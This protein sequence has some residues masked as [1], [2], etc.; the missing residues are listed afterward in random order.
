M[1]TPA[2]FISYRRNDCAGYA[3]RLEDALE[4]IYGKGSVFRDVHDIAAGDDFKAVIETYLQGVR[5]SLVLIG[6]QWFGTRPDGSRR[7]DEPN[8]F[9][10]LEVLTAVTRTAKVVPILL[11]GATMPQREHL[12]EALRALADKQALTLEE[13]SWDS[14]LQRL[15]SSLDIRTARQRRMAPMAVGILLLLAAGGVAYF[16]AQHRAPAAAVAVT[17]DPTEKTRAALPGSWQTTVKYYW[18]DSYN[19]QFVFKR[20]AGEL[21]G[22]ASY[23]AYPR[24]IEQ[25]AINDNTV[26]FLTHTYQSMNEQQRELTHTYQA[27]LDG[28]TLHVRMLTT[29]GFVS[30]QP[31]EFTMTRVAAT[32]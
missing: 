6:P 26:R 32:Q 2:I 21:T 29:G 5:A 27:E 1:T 17:P 24:G 28:D 25:L 7:I 30:E 11:E 8:D 16:T 10:R 4:R 14:D 22:T 9:V 18:G 31:L 20:F 12:P 19:E 15:V 23:L 3:G 13:T